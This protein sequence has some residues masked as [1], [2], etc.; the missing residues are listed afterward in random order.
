MWR[1]FYNCTS[2][3]NISNTRKFS[4]VLDSVNSLLFFFLLMIH[5]IGFCCVKFVLKR[6]GRDSLPQLA[7]NRFEIWEVFGTQ[8]IFKIQK[9][10][11]FEIYIYSNT[12]KYFLQLQFSSKCKRQLAINCSRI[13]SPFY[14]VKYKYVIYKSE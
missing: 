13:L 8:V 3:Q 12:E 2:L 4:F 11:P 6:I 5:C 7:R 1:T 9:S 14:C 10:L